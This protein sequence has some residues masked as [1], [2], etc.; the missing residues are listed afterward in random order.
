MLLQISK[1]TP[2]SLRVDASKLKKIQSSTWKHDSRENKNTGKCI[3]MGES[4][5][6]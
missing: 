3:A 1:Y 2:M 5:V 6:L 4:H